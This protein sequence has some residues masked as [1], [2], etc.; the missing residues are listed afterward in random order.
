VPKILL[1]EN[2]TARM[3]VLYGVRTTACIS[4]YST[5]TSFSIVEIVC[6]LCEQ[7]TESSLKTETNVSL[8]SNVLFSTLGTAPIE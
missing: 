7:Q 3:C 8:Q 4:P 2:D 1:L 5:N 6:F